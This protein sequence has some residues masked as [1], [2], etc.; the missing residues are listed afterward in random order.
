MAM[1]QRWLSLAGQMGVFSCRA[2]ASAGCGLPCYGYA[3]AVVG[4]AGF[5]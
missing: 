1:Q 5:G 2:V 4:H 3:V